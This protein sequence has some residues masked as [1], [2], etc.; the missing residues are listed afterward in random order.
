MLL[1]LQGYLS[2]FELAGLP[3]LKAGSKLEGR[4][5]LNALDRCMLC[6]SQ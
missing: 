3:G 4:K 2:G 6:F 5:S 1:T